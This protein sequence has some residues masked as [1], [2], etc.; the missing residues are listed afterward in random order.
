MTGFKVFL[1]MASGEF[2]P[3]RNRIAADLNAKKLTVKWQEAFRQEPGVHSLLQLLH[4]YIRDCDAVVCV[5]GD[6]SGSVPPQADVDRYPGVVAAELTQASYTQWEYFF[7]RK[8]NKRISCY[9]GNPG[10]RCDPPGG[11]DV[12]G[13]Q[14]R[15]LDHV[16]A[17][18]IYVTPGDSIDGLRAEIL[19]EPWPDHRAAKPIH[20]PYPSLGP[21]FKGRDAFL[22]A[23]HDSLT[24]GTGTAIMAAIH[25]MGGVGK[26]RAAVEYAWTRALTY[27]ALLFVQAGSPDNLHRGL[28]GL[29]VTLRIP[30]D[31]TADQDARCLAVL[32]WLADNS[33]WLLI[34]D[35]VDT[36]E[37]VGA[38][39][40]RLKNLQCGCILLTSRLDYFDH[41]IHSFP[42]H[43]LAPSDAVAFLR[44]A[45]TE[46]RTRRPDD[47]AMALIL[48]EE[49]GHLALALEM[50]AATINQRRLDFIGYQTLWRQSRE[51][52]LGWSSATIPT[53]DRIVAETW[54]TSVDQLSCDG[55]TLLEL[56]AFLAPDP[57]PESLLAVVVPGKEGFN[58]R[59]GMIDLAGYSLVLRDLNAERF[60]LHRLVQEATLR[61][62][63]ADVRS[64]PVLKHCLWRRLVT[65]F[66]RRRPADIATCRLTEAL[67]WVDAAFVGDA[68]DVRSW[69]VLD[70]LM[71]HAEAVALHGS[72]HEI[73]EP[74]V[75]LLDRLSSLLLHHALFARAEIVARAALGLIR[76]AKNRSLDHAKL[77]SN[78]ALILYD[79]NKIRE[80]EVLFREALAMVKSL[81]G[82]RCVEYASVMNNFSVLLHDTNRAS[83][84]EAM[85][86][87][88]ISIG[89]AELPP[90]DPT[91]AIWINNLAE[92]YR[93]GRLYEK[94]EELYLRVL[95]IDRRVYGNDHPIVARG[96]NNYGINLMATGR[97]S[98]SEKY[99]QE[100]LQIDEAHY[101]PVHPDV[102][103]DLVNLADL[104]RA[105]REFSEAIPLYERALGIKALAFGPDHPEVA[106][107]L[108]GIIPHF[109]KAF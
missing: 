98:E 38:V 5:W 45:T 9:I 12:P 74:T 41:A 23:I 3:L 103:R 36:H 16:R 72:D 13:V 39:T 76:T 29:T 66:S 2:E 53:Y 4:D 30:L 54:Q 85:R 40:A 51:K 42:L 6:R 10:A 44:E 89:E 90:H 11:E 84:A 105:K 57:V 27:T 31:E 80:S 108:S 48:A 8:F 15:F 58:A 93:S 67:G 28:A 56:L 68:H 71:N 24:Q 106:Q 99:L 77:L 43:E 96:L 65:L 55:R 49:L 92:F 14:A 81:R 75:R 73:L 25:G 91:L 109:D 52:V 78:T 61:R 62:L 19:K 107:S 35:N 18:S 82:D 50:A 79:Q 33:N 34:L 87:Q 95:E 100:A 32:R 70:P 20:L 59:E 63:W 102:A 1:S 94:A 97:L 60:S 37:A 26:T 22:S 101:G 64:A 7:A 104:R 46:R 47:A 83:D 17:Q 69:V 21:L 88:V 86:L